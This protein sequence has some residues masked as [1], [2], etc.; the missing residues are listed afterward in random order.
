MAG[1]VPQLFGD[2]IFKLHGDARSAS[3]KSLNLDRTPKKVVHPQEYMMPLENSLRTRP[4]HCGAV[5][6]SRPRYAPHSAAP[7]GCV[8][9]GDLRGVAE[10]AS[11]CSRHISLIKGCQGGIRSVL[12][13]RGRT[14]LGDMWLKFF[15][16]AVNFIFA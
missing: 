15:L 7:C 2:E 8:N 1:K 12:V 11:N 14:P 10:G 3:G 16:I 5:Q 13:R 9:S 4:A 6:C